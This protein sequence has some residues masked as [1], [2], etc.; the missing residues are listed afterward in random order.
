L[1]FSERK[2]HELCSLGLSK[3]FERS[4]NIR[5][6]PET[7]KYKQ[8]NHQNHEQ[9]ALRTRPLPVLQGAEQQAQRYI[10]SF[11]AAEIQLPRQSAKET[12]TFFWKK[13]NYNHI[14]APGACGMASSH[15][16]EP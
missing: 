2:D 11:H 12:P 14:D 4:S 13:G 6:I 9:V 7:T 1:D 10:S 15:D 8:I 5:I 3:I 16:L